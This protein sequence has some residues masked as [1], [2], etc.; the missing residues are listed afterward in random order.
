MVFLRISTGFILSVKLS[1]LIGYESFTIFAFIG[2]LNLKDFLFGSSGDSDNYG[3]C[4]INAGLYKDLDFYS[5]LH[6]SV[7]NGS[8]YEIFYILTN[9]LG[10]SIA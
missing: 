7:K 2:D 6:R 10:N 1:I 4:F 8:V 5:V 9:G 3:I